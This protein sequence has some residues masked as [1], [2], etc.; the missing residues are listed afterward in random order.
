MSVEAPLAPRTAPHVIVLGSEKGD[1]GNQRWRSTL[2]LSYS[3]SPPSI[4]TLTHFID[5]RRDCATRARLETRLPTL[6]H[7]QRAESSSV[8]DNESE[9]FAQLHEAV[10]GLQNNHGFVV[11]DTPPSDSFLMCLAHGMAD[12]LVTPLNDSFVDLLV[13]GEVDPVM[14]EV[15]DL[16]RYADLVRQAR[17]HRWTVD[18]TAVKWVVVR[19][20]F[21]R[22]MGRHKT[23]FLRQLA[24]RLGFLTIDGLPEREAYEAFL[25]HGLTALDDAR[26]VASAIEFESIA[27]MR[28]EVRSFVET[29]KL[30]IDELQPKRAASRDEWFASR[31]KPIE[32]DILFEESR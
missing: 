7:V 28:E 11:I 16:G 3:A 13:F 31:D 32:S 9:K 25:P 22:P 15:A 18:H 23:D 26:E 10:V 17:S 1:R 12:T 30:P 24:S 21:S 29:L 27:E 5:S 19:N 20:R 4:W 14:F 6:Y 2:R 8:S